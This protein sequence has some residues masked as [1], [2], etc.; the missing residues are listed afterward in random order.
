VKKSGAAVK[1]TGTLVVRLSGSRSSHSLTFTE[2][3]LS[4]AEHSLG[5]V[6]PFDVGGHPLVVH[7]KH[8]KSLPGC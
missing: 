2:T 7:I 8:V 4:G 5:L 3:G 1:A 6:S